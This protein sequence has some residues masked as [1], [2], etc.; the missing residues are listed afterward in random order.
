VKTIDTL[1]VYIW[2]MKKRVKLKIGHGKSEEKNEFGNP[3]TESL[4]F[5]CGT[6]VM[7]GLANKRLPQ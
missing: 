4:G 3:W 7:L 5:K 2:N 1:D 6:L